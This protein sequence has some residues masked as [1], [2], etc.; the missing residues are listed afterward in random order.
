MKT[1]P[2]STQDHQQN[3]MRWIH[4]MRNEAIRLGWKEPFR[5]TVTDNDG[6]MLH[7]APVLHAE[8]I[9][10]LERPWADVENC[11]TINLSFVSEDSGEKVT[12]LID[13]TTGP[14]SLPQVGGKTEPETEEKTETKARGVAIPA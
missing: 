6:N 7:E 1:A 14:E 5:V 2:A 3:F 13:L 10:A 4:S 8:G 11:Q 12:Q 9:T